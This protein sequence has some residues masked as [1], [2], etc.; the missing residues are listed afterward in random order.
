MIDN[1]EENSELSILWIIRILKYHVNIN[2]ETVQ[3]LLNNDV[4]INVMLYHI[5]LKLKLVIQ[6]NIVITMKDVRNLKSSFIRYIF[7]VT[8]RIEDVIVKQSF[9]IFE[10]NLNACILD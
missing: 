6:S 5:T 4:E 10:K 3:S 2:K 7:D 9:F 1:N 8:V